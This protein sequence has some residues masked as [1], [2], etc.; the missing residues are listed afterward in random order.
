M[1]TPVKEF[2]SE[3]RPICLPSISMWNEMFVDKFVK[4]FGY[5][6]TEKVPDATKDQVSN[7]LNL[8][9]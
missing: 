3:I 7:P 4:I 2:S 5:G 9:I 6:R 8:V 1:K